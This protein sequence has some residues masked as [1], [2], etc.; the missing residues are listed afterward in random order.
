MEFDFL[1]FLLSVVANCL[2]ISADLAE[3]T[4]KDLAE[5]ILSPGTTITIVLNEP[6]ARNGSQSELNPP[7]QFVRSEL[8]LL[9]FTPTMGKVTMGKCKKR[10]TLHPNW[11][12]RKKILRAGMKNVLAFSLCKMYI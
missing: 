2:F 10:H 9:C 7:L 5:L 3:C 11:E 1:F 8:P 12:R 6:P 4:Y